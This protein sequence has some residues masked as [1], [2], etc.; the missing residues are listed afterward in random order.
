MDVRACVGAGEN[1]KFLMHADL[2][3]TTGVLLSYMGRVP[4]K[5]LSLDLLAH[6]AVHRVVQTRTRANLDPPRYLCRHLSCVLFLLT[7]FFWKGRR[8][9]PKELE[10]TDYCECATCMRVCTCSLRGT[11][12]HMTW[13][14]F[15]TAFIWS[16]PLF[17]DILGSLDLLKDIYSGTSENYAHQCRRVCQCC[18]VLLL[19]AGWELAQPAGRVAQSHHRLGAHL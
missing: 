4:E 19:R 10:S 6:A 16:P 1:H 11:G 17:S 9:E 8:K 7:L 13:A 12:C 15:Q 14:P 2:H 18:V 5:I 3:E